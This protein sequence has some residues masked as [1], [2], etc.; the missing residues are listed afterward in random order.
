MPLLRTETG[1]RCRKTLVSITTTRL[2]RSRGAGWRKMLF[3]TCEV[4]I[5]SPIAMLTPNQ[6]E[7]GFQI[8]ATSSLQKDVRIRVVPLSQLF[9]ELAGLVHHDLA[10]VGLLDGITLERPRR[11]AFEVHARHA[12]ATAVAGAFELLVAF[13]PVGITAQVRADR[14]QGVNDVA[15][16]VVASADYP[17]AQLLELVIDLVLFI[18]VDVTGLEGAGRLREDIGEEKSHRAQ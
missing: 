1:C 11:G 6:K 17:R 16:A 3:Q 10:V 5:Q 2:R 14:G 12:E 9:L 18:A 7:D 13:E 4:F 15:V 8:C